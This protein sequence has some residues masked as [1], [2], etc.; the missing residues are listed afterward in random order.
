[1]VDPSDAG[2]VGAELWLD[3]GR[4]AG[5]GEVEIFQDAFARGVQVCTIGKN[6]VD[7]RGLEHAEAA[8]GLGANSGEGGS[9][10][11]SDL[12][13]DDVG[14]LAREVGDDDDLNVGEVGDGVDAA[15]ATPKCRRLPRRG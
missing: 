8:H 10:R 3:A 15:V 6:D 11:I 14:R 7:H 9:E 12:V 13:L 4:E 1:M 5:L 2:G